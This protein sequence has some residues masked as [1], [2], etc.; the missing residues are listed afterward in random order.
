MTSYIGRR[1]LYMVF[2]MVA[3]SMVG[4]AII[5][6]NPIVSTVGGLLP[7]IVSGTIITAIVLNLPTV[8]PLLFT[9][10]TA[11]DMQLASSIVMVLAIL[12]VIGTFIS[13]MLLLWIDPRIRFEQEQAA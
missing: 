9:A 7:E 1:L 6:V 4:F 3:V 5:A 12:T 10:L 8:G 13:D 11:E 2:T